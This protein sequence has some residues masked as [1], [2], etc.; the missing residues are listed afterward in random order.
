[1]LMNVQF[2]WLLSLRCM[3]VGALLGSK[4][5]GG[6]GVERSGFSASLPTS[7]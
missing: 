2:S 3:Q 1:M 6:D 5:L 4:A 7:P